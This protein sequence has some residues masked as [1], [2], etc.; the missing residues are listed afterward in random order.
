MS[1]LIKALC[2]VIQA[3]AV[4]DSFK[5]LHSNISGL[6]KDIKNLSDKLN[7]SE[8]QKAAAWLNHIGLLSRHLE[9]SLDAIKE[10]EGAYRENESQVK[11]PKVLK[12]IGDFEDLK[13]CRRAILRCNEALDTGVQIPATSRIIDNSLDSVYG[14]WYRI[15]SWANRL[16]G[17]VMN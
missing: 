2:H 11:E 15:R 6:Q 13:F 14:S 4:D 12:H 16:N 17:V 1:I 3:T 5:S 10:A 7:K 8:D 9:L